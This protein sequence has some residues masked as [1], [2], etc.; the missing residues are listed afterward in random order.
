MSHTEDVWVQKQI[1]CVD[2][3]GQAATFDQPSEKH[4]LISKSEVATPPRGGWEGGQWAGSTGSSVCDRLGHPV[5]QAHGLWV[6]TVKG[7]GDKG[8]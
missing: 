7:E 3:S 2:A 5:T 4:V 6:R 8:G 1:L